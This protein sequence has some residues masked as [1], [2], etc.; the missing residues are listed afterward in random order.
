MELKLIDIVTTRPKIPKYSSLKLLGAFDRV[1][2]LIEQYTNIICVEYEK[3][4]Y[5]GATKQD[6]CDIVGLKIGFINK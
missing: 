2:S 1:I 5:R 4:K 3:G 6:L